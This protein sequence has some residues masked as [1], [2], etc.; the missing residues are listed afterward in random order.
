MRS[1]LIEL[2]EVGIWNE[3][4][5][6]L[7]EKVL[8]GELGGDRKELWREVGRN[9]VGLVGRGEVEGEVGGVGVGEEEARKVSFSIVFYFTLS[10]SAFLVFFSSFPLFKFIAF[11]LAHPIFFLLSLPNP[12]FSPL[13]FSSLPFSPR[14]FNTPKTYLTNTL[15][16]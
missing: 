9:R 11:S 3:W 10:L 7:R 12:F 4:V 15:K 1:E 14:N 13:L 16:I 6:E 8:K 5:R 2:E